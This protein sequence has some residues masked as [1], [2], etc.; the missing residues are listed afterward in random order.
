MGVFET[1]FAATRY[2]AEALNISNTVGTIE[3]GKIADMVIFKKDITK[4]INFLKKENIEMV[5][6][7][8]EVLNL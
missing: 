8:G 6:K 7:A 2:A 1:L 5:I 3:K 4:D